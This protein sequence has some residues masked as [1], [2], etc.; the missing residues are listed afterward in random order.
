MPDHVRGPRAIGWRRRP[1][2]IPFRR[3]TGLA[4]EVGKA[5]ALSLLNWPPRTTTFP[6]IGGRW[7]CSLKPPQA[8]PDWSSKSATVKRRLGAVTIIVHPRWRVRGTWPGQNRRSPATEAHAAKAHLGVAIVATGALSGA[9]AGPAARSC[10]PADP[11][12]QPETAAASKTAMKPC[13]T[14]RLRAPRP[15]RS[16]LG[17]GAPP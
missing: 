8:T 6:K 2:A 5:R 15:D 1:L 11:P 12:E 13:L 3:T 14:L 7:T 9:A 4:P 16:A 10:G 17:P